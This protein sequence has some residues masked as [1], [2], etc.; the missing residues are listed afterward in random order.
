[1]AI[2]TGGKIIEGS[3]LDAP[4]LTD[5]V[6]VNGT[7]GTYAGVAAVGARLINTTTGLQ[8]RN[9]NTQASPTWIAT[10]AA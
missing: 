3:G 4:L 5:V 2:I 1:M 10:D 9:S 7:S 6:P 8:Y